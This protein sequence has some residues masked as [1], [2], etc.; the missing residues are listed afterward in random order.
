MKKNFEEEEEYSLEKSATFLNTLR[1]ENDLFKEE[2]HVPQKLIRVSR[3]KDGDILINSDKEVVL[4]IKQS[5]LN[6]KQK[7]FLN[8]VEGMKFLIVKFKEGCDS[9]SK[10]TKELKL[11]IDKNDNI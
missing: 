5:S 9:L 7:K 10:I 1:I 2:D 11:H 3:N 4:T 8:E 6:Q